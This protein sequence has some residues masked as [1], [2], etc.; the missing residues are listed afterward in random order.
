MQPVLYTLNFAGKVNELIRLFT[1]S[2]I[3]T[4]FDSIETEKFSRGNVRIDVV[5]VK[6]VLLNLYNN[7][8]LLH[9]Y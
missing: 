3:Q 4:N 7:I 2:D 5:I 1:Y 9:Y 6:K 8:K